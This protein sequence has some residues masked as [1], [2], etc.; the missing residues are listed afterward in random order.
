MMQRPSLASTDTNRS[1]DRSNAIAVAYD[2][3]SSDTI[4]SQVAVTIHKGGSSLARSALDV[5]A[6]SIIDVRSHD[7]FP[8]ASKTSIAPRTT[9]DA[10]GDALVPFGSLDRQTILD[11]LDSG[12]VTGIQL[13]QDEQPIV[14]DEVE[15]HPDRATVARVVSPSK[16]KKSAPTKTRSPRN[17][18]TSASKDDHKLPTPVLKSEVAAAICD[19]VSVDLAQ[20]FPMPW[21]LLDRDEGSTEHVYHASSDTPH[22]VKQPY[23]MEDL[24]ISASAS[25]GLPIAAGTS[26]VLTIKLHQSVDRRNESQ[27]EDEHVHA[28]A[29]DDKGVQHD[30]VERYDNGCACGLANWPCYALK[31]DRAT[32]CA[33]C[34]TTGMINVTKPY[35][36]EEGC[37][38][39]PSYGTKWRKPLYCLAHKKDG[40]EQVMTA[41]CVVCKETQPSFGSLRPNGR[42]GTKTHCGA[43]KELGML[44]LSNKMCSVCHIIRCTYG[45]QQGKPTHCATCSTVG[46][47]DVLNKMCAK[48][49]RVGP[50]YGKEGGP[51]THCTKCKTTDMVDLTAINKL[52][53]TCITRNERKRATFGYENKKPLYCAACKPDDLKVRDVVHEMCIGEGCNMRACNP[54]YQGYCIRCCIHNRPDIEVFRNYKTKERAVVEFLLQQFPSLTWVLDKKVGSSLRRPDARADMGA[55][56]LIVEIDERKHTGKNGEHERLMQISEDIGHKPLIVI[57]I[58]PDA[59]IDAEGKRVSSC[60]KIDGAGIMTITKV[61]EWQTR[62][63]KLEQRVDRWI[64]TACTET[65]E[66]EH[67]FYDA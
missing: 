33:K 5:T 61:D 31:G 60:W 66:V 58:N 38:I 26:N 14:W 1:A 12:A 44:N 19:A 67:L 51:R 46:M 45:K 54:R 55:Y 24:T 20:A 34:Q 57:R 42:K 59:Y 37:T 17:R 64:K 6:P 48:C 39:A 8:F 15:P 11:E 3:A 23:G 32:H 4:V 43:C 53:V 7:A 13:Y 18:R 10:R 29:M 36:I 21:G 52:C 47:R 41:L 40:M 25:S 2:N 49:E 35:C 62:L 9:A 30:Q 22:C 27:H 50:S 28:H 65:L 63:F 16:A 56:M